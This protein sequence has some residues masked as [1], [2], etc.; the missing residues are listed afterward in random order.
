MGSSRLPNK[1]L[2]DLAGQ[3]MLAHVV[4][5]TCGAKTLDDVVVATTTQ[6]ADDTSPYQT[7]CRETGHV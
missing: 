2:E 4:N 1:V 6:P 5:R 3:P 7:R